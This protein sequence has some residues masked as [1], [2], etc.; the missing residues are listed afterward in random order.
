MS[1][2]GQLR[3]ALGTLIAL[4]L[5]ILVVAFY[6]PYELNSS[7]NSKYVEDVI[8]L[9]SLVDHLV[10]QMTREEAAV[11]AYVVTG[12]TG[13]R[14]R[15]RKGQTAV[16]KD[17]A[18]MRLY[19]Q[20]HPSLAPLL[21]LATV[22]IADLQGLF[23]RQVAAVDR[24]QGRGTARAQIAK[25]KRKFDRFRR[26]ANLMVSETRRFTEDAKREQQSTYRR[27]L[28][29]LGSLG[30]LAIA[31]GGV[32]LTVTPRRLG[33]LY[34]SEE[35]SR[36]EAES[37]A[38]AARALEHVSDGV[39][40]TDLDG[41]I[42]FWNPAAAQLT[43]LEPARALGQ[44][45][46]ALLPA[47]EAI[48]PAGGGLEGAGAAV[49]PLQ[50]AHRERWLSITS[51]DFGEGR[52]YA[53]RDVTE[54][55]LLETMRSEFVATASHELRTPMTGIYGAARTLL[56]LGDDLE[57]ARR[58]AFL[59]MIVTESERLSRIVDGILLAN[60]IDAGSVEIAT[61]H[62]DARALA[63]SVLAAT[64]VGAPSSIT[65][66]LDSPSEL[67]PVACDPDRLRQVLVNLVDN[68]IKYSP[69]GGEVRV[70]LAEEDGKMRFAVHDEGL[71]FPQSEQERIFERF[72]RLDPHLSRG[73]GGT[74]LGLYI[75]RELV[76]RMH[77]R[78]WAQSEPGQ[79][80]TFYIELPLADSTAKAD[81]SG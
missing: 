30:L 78:I 44:R 58:R 51:V 12:D 33:Q 73:I 13:E 17:L 50:L 61:E 72:H 20:R 63:D 41:R 52:V 36:R 31:L 22:Q 68:A 35:R 45:L 55:R 67:S 18:A 9:R 16:N 24:G 14:R 43:D 49:V 77:G 6:V 56:R 80:S 7:A 57:P 48:T 65:F 70:E 53:L 54:E 2:A 47:L 66:S 23:E 75:S 81:L 76:E 5:G 62:C 11:Q 25:I 37:R 4:L 27:L 19:G 15:F 28:L 69:E 79:G 3:L 74:G 39:I 34:E 26:T 29:A 42:R 71:G 32:L 60:R 8:P 40:L 64:E 1:V 10:L 46:G 38:D 21:R 59:E